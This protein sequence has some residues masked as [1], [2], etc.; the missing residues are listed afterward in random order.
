[1]LTKFWESA[2]EQL[3]GSWFKE[4]FG[5]A[6]LF[7]SGGLVIIVGKIGFYEVWNWISSRDIQTQVSALIVGIL[8]ITLSG[9][10][11]KQLRFSFLRFL[12]GYWEGPFKYFSNAAIKNQQTSIE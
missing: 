9:Q 10:L 4:L 11:M 6:F 12:E 2:G 7:W 5:P 1:M 3:A 8:I